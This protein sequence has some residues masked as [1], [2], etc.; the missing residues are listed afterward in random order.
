MWSQSDNTSSSYSWHSCHHRTPFT[1]TAMA[2]HPSDELHQICYEISTW[3]TMVFI[4]KHDLKRS[5]NVLAI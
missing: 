4:T 5:V 2:R 1:A 3:Q